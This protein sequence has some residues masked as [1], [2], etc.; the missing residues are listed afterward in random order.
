MYTMKYSAAMKM[1]HEALHG[2]T[3]EDTQDI[4]KEIK[5]SCRPDWF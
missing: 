4:L 2:L 1:K 3:R 5:A